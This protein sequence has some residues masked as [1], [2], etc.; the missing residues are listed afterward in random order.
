M[1]LQIRFP[2]PVLAALTALEEAGYEAYLVGGC[3]RDLLRGKEPNDYDLTTN[4]LPEAV[5]K[6][7]SH[8]RVIETGIRHGTVT[9][10]LSGMSLEITTYRVDGSYSDGRHPDQVTFTP[11]LTEDLARRDFTVNAMACDRFGRICDP[12]GGQADLAAGILRC[13]GEPSRRFAEDALRIL[14]ALRFSAVLGYT[15]HPRTAEAAEALAST[16]SVVSAERVFAEMTKLLCGSHVREVLCRYPRILG[17]WIPE[18]L[19]C[20]GLDQ[21]NPHHCYDLLTHTAVAVEQVPAEPILRW[22]AFLHD[23]G[24]AATKTWDAQG[25]GHYYGHAEQSALYADAILRRL[26]TDT[27]TRERVVLLIRHHDAPIENTEAILRRRLSRLGEEAFFQL[28][29][30]KQGDN[31]AQAPEY[32][33]RIQ[34]LGELEVAARALLQAENSCFTLRELAVTGKELLAMGVPQGK[35]LGAL[36]HRLLEAVLD[37]T[38]VNE[39]EPLLA[40]ARAFW[41]G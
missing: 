18:L 38:L 37:G 2:A 9:V 36:L 11:Q 34:M 39:K 20:V 29:A 26:K 14:R 31:L 27:A 7:F 33:T 32:R 23:F 35:E 15:I 24:K 10:L 6:V 12:F 41:K 21:E 4:A 19:P 28:L 1:K 3:V 13:V 22:A 5:A 16:L 40:A 25:V 30:L 8:C 17:V